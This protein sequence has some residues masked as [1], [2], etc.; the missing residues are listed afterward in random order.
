MNLKKLFNHSLMIVLFA[1]L[2]ITLSGCKNNG[3]ADDTINIKVNQMECFSGK[4]KQEIYDIRKKYVEKSIFK[5][6]DY[7][8]SEEVFGQIEDGLPWRSVFTELCHNEDNKEFETRGPS[9]ESRF[10]NNPIMLV[11]LLHWGHTPTYY[12]RCDGTIGWAVP[13]RITYSKNNKLITA[14]YKNMHAL[15]KDAIYGIETINAQ[16]FGYRYGKMIS[17]DEISFFN[18][19]D[20]ISTRIYE[21][22]NFIHRGDSCGLEGGC[23]N[24]SPYIEGFIFAPL[25]NSKNKQ[26][27]ILVFQ[28]WKSKPKNE[29]TTCDL[30]YKII[31]DYSKNE[32]E[33]NK[34]LFFDRLKGV[35]IKI[36]N[37]LTPDS[38][39]ESIY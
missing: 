11:G 34:Y 9:E 31:F 27:K 37:G 13:Y 21:F 15:N 24:C 22:Q 28:L 6:K 36:I 38:A 5:S 33:Y 23:N 25:L 26:T 29:N 32:K 3:E 7:E 19:N 17:N 12:R 4:T 14:Y 10:I 16:D 8:P 30:T 20:N 39:G 18:S 1:S 35:Y 2:M